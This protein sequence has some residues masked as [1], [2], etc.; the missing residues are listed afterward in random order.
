LF[1]GVPFWISTGA[2]TCAVL[3]PLVGMF[4]RGS[5]TE[6]RVVELETALWIAL[7]TAGVS[8]TGGADS[9]LLVLFAV[10]VLL[11]WRSGTP[12]LV[13]ETAGFSLLGYVLAAISGAGEPWFDHS[14]AEMIGMSFGACG[15]VLIGLT[16]AITR[17]LQQT[18][19][20]VSPATTPVSGAATDPHAVLRLRRAET[21]LQQAEAELAKARAAVETAEASLGRAHGSLRRPATNCA[22]R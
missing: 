18:A 5:A 17:P 4:L 1:L 3:P 13:A 16:A 22:R 2:L 14:A 20:A 21:R 15:L 19:T 7:A 6:A 11:A 12:R 8:S 9:P 10:A